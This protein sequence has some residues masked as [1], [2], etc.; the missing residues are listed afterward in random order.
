MDTPLR[1]RHS[2][3]VC[4][5]L[6]PGRKFLQFLLHVHLRAGIQVCLPILIKC[7]SLKVVD[8][9]YLVF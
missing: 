8:S 3:W 7:I 6:I 5:A 9:S 1:S 2:L 4:L